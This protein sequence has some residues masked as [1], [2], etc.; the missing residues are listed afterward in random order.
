[1]LSTY[2][3]SKG[4]KT[5]TTDAAGKCLISLAVKGD[6]QLITVVLRAGDRYSESIALLNYGFNSMQQIKVI[7]SQTAYK[8][9]RVD[10]GD[11]AKVP[12]Y[13]ERDVMI[14]LPENGLRYLEKRVILEY[15]PKAPVKKGDRIGTLEV[16]YKGE[17][18]DEVG[19]KA[20]AS[21]QKVPQG[22]WKLLRR[23]VAARQPISQCNYLSSR[24]K[25]SIEIHTRQF[26]AS[27]L[28]VMLC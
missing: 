5:G 17:L 22:I 25:L 8:S 11:A 4:I 1:L 14:W 2:P 20:G 10:N 9:L 26:C 7:D 12:I 21:V 23:A 27:K 24:V 3:G 16:Y 18:A 13:P 28:E 15:R 19:L 6:R